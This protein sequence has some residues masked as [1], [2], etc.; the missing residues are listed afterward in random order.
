MKI[1]TL[2]WIFT[3]VFCAF[4]IIPN[5]ACTIFLL[6]DSKRTWFFNNEDYS[7]PATRI[8]FL[9]GG[10]EY[11]GV[12][13]VGFDNDWPQGGFNTAGLAFDWVAGF[14]EQFSPDQNYLNLGESRMKE[15]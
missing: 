4:F 12:T 11:Y 7:N 1:I 15:C 3:F 8:W 13:Y 9:P 2:K 14:Q 6:T 10:K 5:Y